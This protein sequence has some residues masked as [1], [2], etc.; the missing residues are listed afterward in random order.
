MQENGKL[1]FFLHF[2]EISM[3][4]KTYR[5]THKTS[6]LI[7]KTPS[8]DKPEIVNYETVCLYVNYLPDASKEGLVPMKIIC[9]YPRISKAHNITF[10]LNFYSD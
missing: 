5:H 10:S 9:L 1:F 8:G 3:V 6:Y 4:G 7:L 2:L